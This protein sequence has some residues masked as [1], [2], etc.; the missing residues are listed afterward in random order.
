MKNRL[1][2]RILSFLFGIFCILSGCSSASRGSED[3]AAV[4]DYA[5]DFYQKWTRT[6]KI[7]FASMTVT[8]T[9]ASER[10]AWYKIGQRK[11]VYSFDIYL[12]GYIDMDEMKPSDIKLDEAQKIISVNLPRVR[13]EIIGRSEELRVEYENI[14]IFRSKP[15]SRERAELKEKANADFLKEFK[16]N[17][18]YRSQLESMAQA[19]ARAYFKMLG[20]AAG[21]KVEFTNTL[22]LNKIKG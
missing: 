22:P 10:S 7:D 17:P 13:S 5:R 4:V 18:A 3:S 15:D 2:F 9:I 16:T 14:G 21:Y 8:K 1:I 12:R 11:A 20:E 19:N 6:G